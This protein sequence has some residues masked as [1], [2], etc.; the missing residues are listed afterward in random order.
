[1][2]VV[3][4]MI[5]AGKTTISTLLAKELGYDVICEKVD[6]SIVLPLFYTSTEEERIKH[7]YPFLLQLEFL[8]ARF[9]SIKEGLRNHGRRT[10]MD[11]SIYED[12]YFAHVNHQ[13][14]GISDLEMKIYSDLLNNMM[15]EI[16]EIPSKAPDLFIYLHADFEIILERIAQR[17]REFE[18]GK[19]LTAYY[20]RLWEGYDDWVINCYDE[21]EVLEINIGEVDLLNDLTAR[22]E[23]LTKI[24]SYLKA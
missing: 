7:R 22:K 18:Q 11:R 2:I 21:S 5:G 14:G 19:E 3:G 17:G 23:I 20:R 24:R 8:N 10:V 15:Q 16:A 1:M 13:L 4:G 12:W 6:E 9:S